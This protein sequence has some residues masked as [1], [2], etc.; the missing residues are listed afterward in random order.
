MKKTTRYLS[1]LLVMLLCGTVL[2][3]SCNVAE[4]A[5]VTSTETQTQ[6]TEAFSFSEDIGIF[7]EIPSV[8]TEIEFPDNIDDVEAFMLEQAKLQFDGVPW[9]TTPAQIAEY[10]MTQDCL[11]QENSAF[12]HG[13]EQMEAFYE[14]SKN[15]KEGSIRIVTHYL[16]DADQPNDEESI[17]LQLICFDGVLYHTITL[18]ANGEADTAETYTYLVHDAGHEDSAFVSLDYNHYFLSDDDSTTMDRIMR[19]LLSSSV[20]DGDLISSFHFVC[21]EYTNRVVKEYEYTNRVVKE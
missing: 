3:T 21:T 2:F 5:G 10:M 13:R 1:L 15:G 4:D 16:D 18:N 8:G 19:A 11:V 14:Q 20:V 6:S 17:Y 7:T 9:G 12:I